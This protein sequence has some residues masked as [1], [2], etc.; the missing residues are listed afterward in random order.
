MRPVF[1]RT[2]VA[3]VSVFMPTLTLA[4]AGP[5]TPS[6][7][8]FGSD[9][10][11]A[12]DHIDITHP[13]PGDAFAAGSYVIVSAK[14]SGDLIATGGQV[15]VTSPVQQDAL[16]AGGRIS[17]ASTINRNARVAGGDVTLQPGARINGNASLAGGNLNVAGAVTGYLMAGGGQ[18]YLNGPVDGDVRVSGEDIK[19]GPNARIKGNLYYRSRHGLQR[20]AGAQIG[21]TVERLP[22]PEHKRT[23][24]GAFILEIL[25]W[26]L[27][28]GVVAAILLAT[29]PT[30]TQRVSSAAR[31]KPGWSLLLGIITFIAIPLMVIVALITVI[32]IPIG[33]L[34]ALAYPI[35]LVVG[36]VLAAV[37]LGD[38]A[39]SR[40]NPD[41]ATERARRIV[42]TFIALLILAILGRIP[43]LGGII[44]VLV[45]FLGVGALIRQMHRV[46]APVA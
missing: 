27:G 46:R 42:A 32:G 22:W 18:I 3:C 12:G 44:C 8:D 40:M 39:L 45:L 43:F 29:L 30:F 4:Q 9:H 1:I 23:G 14:V 10:F 11:V 35:L 28:L 36:Y 33:L 5:A 6:E 19:L 25:I 26:S 38:V 16:I 2:L 7:F 34:G 24:A 37:A 13:V 15:D 31:T 21:G 17:L 41:R 20:A